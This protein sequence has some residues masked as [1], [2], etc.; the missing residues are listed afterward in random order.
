MLGTIA[1]H[2]RTFILTGGGVCGPTINLT[3]ATGLLAGLSLFDADGSIHISL[4]V[5]EDTEPDL[6]LFDAVGQ[7]LFEVP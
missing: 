1:V 4:G 3:A 2:G 6:T 5:G 7:R